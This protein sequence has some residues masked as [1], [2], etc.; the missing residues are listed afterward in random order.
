MAGASGVVV[1]RA[2][3][4]RGIAVPVVQEV[5]KCGSQAQRVC[6]NEDDATTMTRVLIWALNLPPVLIQA[7]N[8]SPYL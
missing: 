3:L 7:L 2:G 1:V 4:E 8:L 6:P 5:A